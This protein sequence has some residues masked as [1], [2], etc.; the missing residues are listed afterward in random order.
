M[1]TKGIE[2]KGAT[3]EGVTVVPAPIEFKNCDIE[4]CKPSVTDFLDD[5]RHSK[6]KKHRRE[7]RG[8]R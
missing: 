3:E 7:A 8:W 6:C 2:A 4:P 5:R 1:T